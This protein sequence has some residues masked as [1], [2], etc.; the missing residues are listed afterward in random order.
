[1]SLEE[2]NEKEVANMRITLLFLAIGRSLRPLLEKPGK[3]E[4][5]QIL[6]FNFL[7]SRGLLRLRKGT[8]PPS[9]FF[10]SLP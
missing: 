9:V 7:W 5:I 1:M 2:I 8:S 6:M 3:R 10:C 4:E